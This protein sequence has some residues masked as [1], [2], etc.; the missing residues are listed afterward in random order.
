MIEKGRKLL[1]KGKI[2][3]ISGGSSAIGRAIAITLAREGAAVSF[4]YLHR[5]E[6]SAGLVRELQDIG[7][8]VRGFKIDIK[9]T[10]AV[11]RW[12][13]E[14]KRI[15]GEIDIV[16]N[17]AGIFKPLALAFTKKKDW[18]EVVDTNLG[19]V[20]NLTQSVI[21]DFIKRKQ[22]VIVNIASANAVIGGSPTNYVASKAGI[23]GFTKSL[24]REVSKY[25]IRVNAIA[26][27]WIDTEMLKGFGQEYREKLYKKIPLG[28]LGQPQEVAGL[29]KFLASER[30][31]FITG[32]TV[33]VDGG[34]SLAI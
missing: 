21:V 29:V 31:N 11:R 2:A 34:I 1:L 33:I 8:P 18:D 17:N 24:A 15:F 20:F 22:G 28:R 13:S 23:I 9:D 19:G 4:S 10:A 7:V 27:G 3:V 12:I 26:P 6:D 5:K 30:A 25:N 16:V 14:T 32:Q